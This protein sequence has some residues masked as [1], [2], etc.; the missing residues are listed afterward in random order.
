[1][2]ANIAMLKNG[3]SK[4]LRAVQTGEEVVVLDRDRPIARLIQ[5]RQPDEAPETDNRLEGLV[6]RGAV[7]HRGNPADTLA[8]LETQQPARPA[9]GSVAISD[10]LLQMRDEERW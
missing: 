5:F 6:R 4:Y 7:T 3:L 8:W 10:V 2:N 1:M 9:T